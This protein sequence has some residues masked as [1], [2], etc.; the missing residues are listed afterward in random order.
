VIDGTPH[1][2]MYVRSG[3]SITLYVDG[4][5]VVTQTSLCSAARG[6]YP[7]QI[8]AMAPGLYFFNGDYRRDPDI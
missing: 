2:A 3:E 1:I 8:G 4:V 5:I 7:V 6:D